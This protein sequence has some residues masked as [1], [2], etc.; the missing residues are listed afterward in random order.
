MAYLKL[1]LAL[2]QNNSR[3]QNC[4]IRHFFFTYYVICLHNVTFATFV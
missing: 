2:I 3:R 4:V 1:N